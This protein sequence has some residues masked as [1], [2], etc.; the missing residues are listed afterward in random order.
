ML[1]EDVIL[2]Y[3][4]YGNEKAL[5][6]NIFAIVFLPALFNGGD[7]AIALSLIFS[8]GIAAPINVFTYPI[9]WIDAPEYS[10]S[11]YAACLLPCI[12]FFAIA[13]IRYF[14]PSLEIGTLGGVEALRLSEENSGKILTSASPSFFDAMSNSIIALSAALCACSVV[15]ITKSRFVIKTMLLCCAAGAAALALLGLALDAL[16]ALEVPAILKIYSVHSFST[17]LDKTEF[18]YF[19]CVWA[20]A[21]FAAGIY[22]FQRFSLWGV[23]SSLRALILASGIFLAAVSIYTAGELF[24]PFIY[25]ACAVIALIYAL[26]ALPTK[27]NLKRHNKRIVAANFAGILKVSAPFIIYIALSVC[28]AAG[29]FYSAGAAIKNNREP[30]PEN[31]EKRLIDADAM[32]AARQKPLFGWGGGSFKNVM[33]ISQGDD[34]KN[35]P[36]PKAS[37]DA[38]KALLENGYCGIAL[39]AAAPFLLMLYII[40]RFGISKSGMIMLSSILALLAASFVLTPFESPSVLISFWIMMGSFIAWQNSKII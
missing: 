8:L 12:A 20:A 3:A 19:A 28:A 17:F 31:M 24:K 36:L 15:I 4:R 6:L 34:I 30:S 5:I 11:K 23:F 21:F 40:C 14:A 39:L 37:S 35:A 33:A 38:V 7:G 9:N 16:F 18:S 32:E 25:A 22:T 1:D 27:S 29:A 26:D 13:F 2:R 10:R